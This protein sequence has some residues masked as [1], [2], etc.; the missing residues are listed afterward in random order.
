MLSHKEMMVNGTFGKIGI[1][2]SELEMID[3]F[4]RWLEFVRFS[5]N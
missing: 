5:C 4:Y 1:S 3:D 2:E